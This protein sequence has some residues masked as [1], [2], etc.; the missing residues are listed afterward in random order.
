MC[1]GK[2]RGVSQSPGIIPIFYTELIHTYVQAKGNEWHA[3]AATD[4]NYKHVPPRSTV[5][6]YGRL[7]CAVQPRVRFSSRF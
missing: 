1:S 4:I 2:E 7:K 6:Y 3:P 5:S